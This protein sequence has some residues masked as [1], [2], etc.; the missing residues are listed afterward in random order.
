MCGRRM[1]KWRERRGQG[2]LPLPAPIPC[3]R[4]RCGWSVGRSTTSAIRCPGAT[5]A[6]QTA[7]ML[8]GTPSQ[9]TRPAAPPGSGRPPP[10]GRFGDVIRSS[11]GMDAL[12]NATDQRPRS[13]LQVGRCPPHPGVTL[14]PMPLSAL[15]HELCDAGHTAPARL[16]LAIRSKHNPPRPP[17]APPRQPAQRPS[18]VPRSP[19]ALFRPGLVMPL[20]RL[21]H[22]DIQHP[23]HE[24]P[25]QRP[26]P[27]V[28]PRVAN[29]QLVV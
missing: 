29:P 17:T 26:N 6:A 5:D 24:R 22:L 4:P 13:A 12:K 11:T 23:R 25:V 18:Q 2:D 21:Q 8:Q 16:P 1:P 19:A 20:R 3:G 28:Q 27:L 10:G 9:P 14:P 7:S 15:F